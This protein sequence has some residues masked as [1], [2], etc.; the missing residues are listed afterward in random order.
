MLKGLGATFP[1]LVV[2]DSGCEKFARSARNVPDVKTL[3][4]E[5]VNVY[6]LLNCNTVVCTKAAVEGIEKRLQK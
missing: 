6:D 1:V 5:G 2:T 4:V 3:P